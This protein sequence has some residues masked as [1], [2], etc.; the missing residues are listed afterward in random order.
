MTPPAGETRAERWMAEGRRAAA[1]DLLR[2]LSHSERVGPVY[3]LAAD[4]EDREHLVPLGAVPWDGP[5]GPFHFGKALADFAAWAGTDALAY[6]GGASAPLLTSTLADEACEQLESATGPLAIVNNLHSTDW[7]LLNSA[8][9]LASLAPL[10][11]TDNPLGWVLSHEGG[12]TVRALPACAATRAD[13]DT[14]A[15]LLLLSRHPDL[16]PATR[17][18]LSCAPEHLKSALDAL[19]EVLA[20]PAKTLTVIGRST[21]HLWQMLERKTQIWVRLFV[22]ERGMLASGRMTRGVVRSLLGEALDSWGPAE[23]VGRVAEMSDAVLWDTRVWLATHGEWPAPAD[24]FAADLGWAEEVQD[25]R[26]RALT[27]ATLQAPIPILTGGHGVVSGSALALLE[28][29][30]DGG[31]P[32]S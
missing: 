14:P 15:D 22:E 13:I 1:S 11:S 6:F 26:L 3:L 17:R 31:A 2:A 24:R 7:I 12:V 20:T 27:E 9:M 21:S 30:P 25:A 18:F 32:I 5:S 29:L 23:F 19:L 10:L 16:G 8:R 4:E 28:A